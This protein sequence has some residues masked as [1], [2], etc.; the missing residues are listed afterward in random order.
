M[1]DTMSD[2][3][4]RRK[5]A[6]ILF[7]TNKRMRA[8][9]AQYAEEPGVTDVLSFSLNFEKNED[10]D[11]VPW[12]VMFEKLSISKYGGKDQMNEIGSVYIAPDYCERVANRRG[13]ATSHY[14]TLATVHGLAHLAGYDH[15]SDDEYQDMKLCE[16]KGIKSLHGLDLNLEKEGNKLPIPL[17]YLT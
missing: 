14:I 10:D 9:A 2:G 5:D 6:S 3:K 12:H 16:E 8:L 4:F 11:G 1:L 17:S 7:V 15:E 13:I